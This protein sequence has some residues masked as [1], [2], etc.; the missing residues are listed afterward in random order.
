MP[1]FKKMAMATMDESSLG[2]LMIREKLVSQTELS[3]LL[4]E[5]NSLKVEE[6]L[7]QFLVRKNILSPEKLEL[8][9]IRQE[10]ERTG[11]VGRQHVLRALNVAKQSSKKVSD[12]VDDFVAN[13]RLVMAKVSEAK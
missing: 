1:S 8:L 2:N 9:L 13:T 7:G 3:E 10:A 5:F 6:L 11:G 4:A 12:G